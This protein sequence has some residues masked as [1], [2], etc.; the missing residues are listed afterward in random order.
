MYLVVAVSA[1]DFDVFWVVCSALAPGNDVMFC[2]VW[3]AGV[4]EASS[5]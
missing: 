2:W 5:V 1:V 3:V 4:V